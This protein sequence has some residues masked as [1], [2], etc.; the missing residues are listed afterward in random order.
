LEIINHVRKL[1]ASRSLECVQA[2]NKDPRQWHVERG[3]QNERHKEERQTWVKLVVHQVVS[4]VQNGEQ[5]VGINQRAQLT[6]CRC[7]A[8]CVRP[9]VNVS[10]DTCMLGTRPLL[11]VQHTHNTSARTHE[12]A[13]AHFVSLTTTTP[14]PYPPSPCLITRTSPNSLVS[15][16]MC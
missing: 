16:Y 10:I 9:R 1:S 11:I 3:G 4:A 5:H 2:A 6:L 8:A 7:G 13:R 12:H 14:H 15:E